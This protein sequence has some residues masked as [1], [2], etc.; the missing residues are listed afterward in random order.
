LFAEADAEFVISDISIIEFYCKETGCSRGRGGSM[1]LIDPDA[2]MMGSAPIVSGTIS[3]TMGAA[4]AASIRKDKRVAVCFFGDGATGEGV[5]YESLNFAA[6]RKL[7]IVFVCEN[8]L[9]ATH[10][11]VRECR[12]FYGP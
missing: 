10:M 5:L 9:Y 8:N 3:L 7:P 12:F 2:G 1:H 4:L 6:L 11:P